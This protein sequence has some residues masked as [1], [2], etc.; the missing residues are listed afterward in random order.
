MAEL[1]DAEDSKS[2]A[3]G[4]PGSSPGEATMEKR[5]IIIRRLHPN[6]RSSDKCDYPKITEL[7][8]CRGNTV[9]EP[10]ETVDELNKNWDKI[11][12]YKTQLDLYK[13]KFG[14]LDA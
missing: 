10:Y 3:F 1:A 9:M 7:L 8:I 4:H 12:E 6:P 5:Y 11:L 14:S 13:A 2:S